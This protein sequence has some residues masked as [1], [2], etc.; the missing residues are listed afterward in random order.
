MNDA[1]TPTEDP[2]AGLPPQLLGTVAAA[3]TLVTDYFQLD[4]HTARRSE[5]IYVQG[6]IED[7]GT[8]FVEAPS[9]E[10]IRPALPANKVS[11][12]IDLGW[13]PPNDEIPNFWRTFPPG[14]LAPGQVASV[15]VRTLMQVYGVTADDEFTLSPASLAAVALPDGVELVDFPIPDDARALTHHDGHNNPQTT[16]ARRW[17]SAPRGGHSRWPPHQEW[18]PWCPT[19]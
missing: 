15:L 14:Q 8:L 7:D 12:L 5:G 6:E 19:P 11:L 2:F 17:G 1:A 16:P 3:L 13:Q 9:N 10:F 18:R 4:A